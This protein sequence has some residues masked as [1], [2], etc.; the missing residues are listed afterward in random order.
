MDLEYIQFIE[1][2][3]EEL[4]NLQESCCVISLFPL[5]E[6]ESKPGLISRFI[7]FIRK[8][9]KAAKK[10]MNTMFDRAIKFIRKALHI[11]PK[12]P[13]VFVGII[14]Q[15]PKSPRENTAESIVDKC[16]S[17]IKNLSLN[18]TVEDSI[19]SFKEAVSYLKGLD[20]EYAYHLDLSILKIETYNFD[21][22][23]SIG[24][25]IRDKIM[26]IDLISDFDKAFEKIKVLYDG[27]K[28]PESIRKDSYKYDVI[29]DMLEDHKERLEYLMDDAQDA[30]KEK[31]I[32]T[33]D[34]IDLLIKADSQ[35]KELLSVKN[36]LNKEI[37]RINSMIDEWMTKNPV[38]GINSATNALLTASRTLFAHNMSLITYAA[39]NAIQS[40]TF[41]ISPI[42]T[43][44]MNF[45][46]K[47]FYSLT[48]ILKEAMKVRQFEQEKR[49]GF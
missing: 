11:K 46:Q 48:T 40:T 37:D 41:I 32:I 27:S 42:S 44:I 35:E 30:K 12:K 6:A 16:D 9:I 10:F 1:D 39:K 45:Y 13:E 5:Q 31:F 36:K 22:I 8:K 49:T 28:T 17:L 18:S 21:K 14:K 34:N 4:I 15:G 23:F 26:S 20:K 29:N 7:G 2:W 25:K 33:M 43:I 3:N 47:I 19:K 24:E 38:N